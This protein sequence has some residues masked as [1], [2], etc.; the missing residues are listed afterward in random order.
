MSFSV[1]SSLCV[2]SAWKDFFLSSNA[3]YGANLL[4]GSCLYVDN[5]RTA[6]TPLTCRMEQTNAYTFVKYM[7]IH[8]IIFLQWLSDPEITRRFFVQT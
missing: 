8:D 7:N 4:Y 6:V 5:N 1:S 2:S 3:S